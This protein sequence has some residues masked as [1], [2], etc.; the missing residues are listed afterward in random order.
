MS[1]KRFSNSQIIKQYEHFE[2]FGEKLK[3]EVQQAEFYE[4]FTRLLE[5]FRFYYEENERKKQKIFELNAMKLNDL[6]KRK[7]ERMEHEEVIKN[8]KETIGHLQAEL[9]EWKIQGKDFI[10]QI[11]NLEDIV[12]EQA[13]EIERMTLKYET[14]EETMLDSTKRKHLQQNIMENN[15]FLTKSLEELVKDT[16]DVKPL[17]LASE[18]PKRQ[19]DQRS[20]KIKNILEVKP[21][22]KLSNEAVKSLSHHKEG[23]ISFESK[24]RD[25]ERLYHHMQESKKPKIMNKNLLKH[26]NEGD[27]LWPE[28][29]IRAKQDV[30]G[31]SKTYHRDMDELLNIE[32]NLQHFK[33]ENKT[34]NKAIMILRVELE[35][36]QKKQTELV[37]NLKE[38]D[39]LINQYKKESVERETRYQ[40]M[41]QKLT[42]ELTRKNETLENITA[43][44]Q[45][46]K[47][48]Q[49]KLK[50][51]L[52][53]TT[54][55]RNI[56]S[57]EAEI[58]SKNIENLEKKVDSLMKAR[59][60][61]SKTAEIFEEHL[62][63]AQARMIMAKQEIEN[64]GKKLEDVEEDMLKL[65]KANELTSSQKDS[66]KKMDMTNLE[67][68]VGHWKN[69]IATRDNRM[70]RIKGDL[71]N[72]IKELQKLKRDICDKERER[73]TAV[74][75]MMR[76]N[77][78]I[79]E[80][81]SALKTLK[82]Q[83]KASDQE[84]DH[85]QKKVRT[86]DLKYQHAY[87]E[88]HKYQTLYTQLC[89]VNKQKQTENSLIGKQH[90]YLMKYLS[91][92]ES[93][94]LKSMKCIR[95]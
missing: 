22:F 32:E 4:E 21:S 76:L 80:Q 3:A 69:Q 68:M 41:Q 72:K 46:V 70:K 55:E 61:A 17:G 74:G 13:N 37:R 67:N 66:A 79:D 94:A 29:V 35:M 42:N 25:M 6:Q 23:K 56:F 33:N 1:T 89:I 95:F 73:M 57:L 62:A 86:L 2:E 40:Q 60:D 31:I 47:V 39:D 19:D 43:K 36:S 59:N 91:D 8:L 87:A 12:Q 78:V 34:L 50:K 64:L 24:S 84:I 93:Q 27:V 88:R 83:L 9:N 58:A 51:E 92:K 7:S 71:I 11:T 53:D 63:Q 48:E 14:Q 28:K 45:N 15:N 30:Y 77:K 65:R 90:E 38:N 85:L 49:D 52:N 81:S 75:E 16:H 82:L 10:K 44:F 20:T 5:Y 54:E 26:K 18:T